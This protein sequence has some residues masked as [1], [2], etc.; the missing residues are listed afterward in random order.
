MIPFTSV[1]WFLLIVLNRGRHVSSF[2]RSPLTVY[3]NIH[4]HG[5]RNTDADNEA[6]VK[7]AQLVDA[8]INCVKISKERFVDGSQFINGG[9]RGKDQM[10]DWVEKEELANVLRELNSSTINPENQVFQSVSGSLLPICISLFSNRDFDITLFH[11]PANSSLPP[12]VHSAGTLLMYSC[13]QGTQAHLKSTLSTGRDIGIDHVDDFILQRIG[14]PARALL[15]NP[16]S[17]ATILELAIHPPRIEDQS[18]E[19]PFGY[20]S[21]EV[22]KLFPSNDA[23]RSILSEKLMNHLQIL[24]HKTLR[25]IKNSLSPDR[26]N[27]DIY[28]SSSSS[29]NNPFAV[30]AWLEESQLDYVLSTMRATVLSNDNTLI[31]VLKQSTA[32]TVVPLFTTEECELSLLIIPAN[33]T[34]PPRN[35]LSGTVLIYHSLPDSVAS[36]RTFVLS[37]E[38]AVDFL[39]SYPIKRL[40]GPNRVIKNDRTLKPAFVLE[41]SIFPPKG[42]AF[43]ESV[44]A[45]D[46]SRFVE[47]ENEVKIIEIPFEERCS[48]IDDK[49][50]VARWD[51]SGFKE[52]IASSTK[53]MFDE[54][55]SFLVGGLGEEISEYKSIPIVININLILFIYVFLEEIR[56]RVL[57]SRQLDQKTMAALGISHVK[58]VLLYGSPGT[59]KT[60][61]AREIAKVLNAREPKVINGPEILD[62]Y[63]GEA[64][65]NIRLLFKD[66]EEE[67]SAVGEKS[68]LH[69]L[70]FD[71]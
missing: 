30:G 27:E 18:P 24:K 37:R 12:R 13:M 38:I 59:G 51:E 57:L 6:P 22:L 14:G 49:R 61:L 46:N 71:E 65:R 70:I 66:A 44:G 50:N 43:G 9:S 64:E 26:R 5:A 40:G 48:L 4:R 8:C 11:I 34:M 62:K 63:V 67:W 19:D 31:S 53:A 20:R 29:S 54:R 55:L 47:R 32:P 69:V 2:F 35:H 33:A 7:L 23:I 39:D 60:L 45:L 15:G 41:M 1:L 42:T 25:C 68:A 56:R 16:H 21:E 58:G 36:V 10:G 52:T 28:Q 3:Q 17:C